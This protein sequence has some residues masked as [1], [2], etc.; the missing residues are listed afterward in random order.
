MIIVLRIIHSLDLYE[1]HMAHTR[2]DSCKGKKTIMSLGCMM[3]KCAVC[4]GVGHVAVIEE[5]VKFVR[6]R[7]VRKPKVEAVVDT[8]KEE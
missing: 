5:V 6:K 8:A 3:K 7:A 2:C 1:L 4:N